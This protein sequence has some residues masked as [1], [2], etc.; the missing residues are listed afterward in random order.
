MTVEPSLAVGQI[1]T[2]ENG[3]LSTAS[4]FIASFGPQG[5]ARNPAP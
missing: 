1:W 3:A 2:G 4:N 5:T